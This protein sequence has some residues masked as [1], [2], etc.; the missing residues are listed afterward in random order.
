MEQT[1]DPN[2]VLWHPG[3]SGVHQGKQFRHRTLLGFFFWLRTQPNLLTPIMYTEK[4]VQD[5]F[6]SH[7]ADSKLVY[8]KTLKE[9][10]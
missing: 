9:H 10:R 8:Q 4:I 6:Q 7:H 3:A 1:F 2:P 5:I